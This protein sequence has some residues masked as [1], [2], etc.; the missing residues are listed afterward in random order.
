VDVEAFLLADAAT[1]QGG[2][3][4][5]IGAFDSI[6]APGAPVNHPQFAIAMRIRFSK[7]E[8]GDHPFRINVVDE[9]GKS[10]LSKPID[11]GVKV[12]VLKA[13]ET[14]AVNLVV[15]F[16]D[17][18]FAKFGKYSIDLTIDGRQRGSLPLYVRP[19]RPAGGQAQRPA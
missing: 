15:N 5:V 7:S 12:N 4:N 9:D 1:D 18:R 16:R 11:A 19:A 10:V 14:L 13:D 8:S 2:K 3:L 6:M 17:V